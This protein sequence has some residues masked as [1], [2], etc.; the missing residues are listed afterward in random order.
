MIRNTLTRALS[1]TSERWTPA[2]FLIDKRVQ[3]LPDER[4]EGQ[5]LERVA[6]AASHRHDVEW[7]AARRA[8]EGGP[9]RRDD[10]D[11]RVS[12]TGGVHERRDTQACA[13][14]HRSRRQPWRR[15]RWVSEET[16]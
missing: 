10:A 11:A 1:G 5:A 13:P 3:T 4:S 16:S 9:L 15:S 14:S 2:L 12:E 6:T 8:S 7:I